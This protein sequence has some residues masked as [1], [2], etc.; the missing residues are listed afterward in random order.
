MC[1]MNQNLILADLLFNEELPAVEDLEALYPARVLKEGA[2]VTRVAPSPTGYLHLG[3]LYVALCCKMTAGHDGVFYVRIE[4]TDKKREIEGGVENITDGLYYFGVTPD[5]GYTNNGE[6]GAYGPYKQSERGKIYR[7]FAKELVLKGLAYPCF[8]TEEDLAKTREGQESRKERTGYYGKFAACRN[9]TV[10][11]VKEKIEAG[12]PFVV[13]LRSGGDP[14][15]KIT[16]EDQIKGKIEMP[17]NDEDFVILKSDGIPTYHFAHAVDDHLMR[18]THVIRGDEWLSSLPKHI[19]LFAA[20]GFKPPKYAHIAP[21]MKLENGNKRKISKRKDPEAAVSYFISRGYPAKSV[22]EYLMTVASSEFEVWRRQNPA[23]EIADFKFNIKK[24][25]VSGALFD[26]EKLDDVS[27]NVI[28]KFDADTVTAAVLNWA[29]E[30]DAGFYK[31]IS[32]DP[33]FLKGIFSIDRGVKNPRK[34][35]ACF[36]DAVEFTRYFYEAPTNFELP[37]NVKASDAA[38]LLKEYIKIYTVRESQSEWFEDLKAVCPAA[39]YCPDTKEYR[40]NPQN[41]SGSVGDFSTV[42]RI[43]ITGRRNSPDLYSI[44]K[45]IG[46]DESINRIKNALRVLEE[47]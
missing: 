4:D 12:L 44:M 6:Q 26:H 46:T 21:I 32:D 15:R 16:V 23:L 10:E 28:S 11:T 9:L 39:G 40:Q 37:E 19:E 31:K 42:L 5:E 8:C 25:S 36:S 29:K 1:I 35:L 30:Y 24:M 17:Q 13:R 27:K 47:T 20:L 3:T 38:K 22:T 43:C 2:K 7:A 33:E 41:Y 34:D 14:D 45:L 18:T